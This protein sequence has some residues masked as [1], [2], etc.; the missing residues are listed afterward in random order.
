MAIATPITMP[1]RHKELTRRD[2]LAGLSFSGA[3]VALPHAAL[4]E[5]FPDHGLPLIN[6]VPNDPDDNDDHPV[7]NLPFVRSTS[8]SERAAGAPPRSFWTVHPSGDFIADCAV[9]TGYAVA[10]LDYMVAANAPEILS[11]AVFDMMRLPRARSGVEVGF[12]TAFGRAAVQGH[13][14]GLSARTGGA[15]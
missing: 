13:A 11:W 10:A 1:D 4:S 12:L 6:A 2:M 7:L 8:A 9:G 15:A 14:A 3:T 5:G